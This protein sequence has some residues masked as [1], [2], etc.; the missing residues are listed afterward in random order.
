M[1]VVESLRIMSLAD[2]FLSQCT[3]NS[4]K[5]IQFSRVDTPTKKVK[6]LVSLNRNAFER[7]FR[8]TLKI[9]WT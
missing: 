1:S 5:R 7:F 6:V 8:Y 2:D 9:S 4:I 3:I